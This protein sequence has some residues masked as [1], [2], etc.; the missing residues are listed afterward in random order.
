LE[1]GDLKEEEI[2]VGHLPLE[3]ACMFAGVFMVYGAL[4]AT[5]YIIYGAWLNAGI[6]I[7]VTALSTWFIFKTWP[8]ISTP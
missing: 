8:K 7:L 6:G 4:F 1:K 2:A 3:L 5:G